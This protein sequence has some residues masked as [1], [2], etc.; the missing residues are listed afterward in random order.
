MPY[1]FLEVYDYENSKSNCEQICSYFDEVYNISDQSS[2][3]SGLS[4]FNKKRQK[5]CDTKSFNFGEDW[6]CNEIVYSFISDSISSYV[7]KYSFLET[8]N[9]GAHWRLCPSYNIQRYEGEKEG[10]FTLHNENS[11]TYPYRMLVWMVYLN[12]AKCG[13]EFPYQDKTVTPKTGRTVIWPAGWTHPHDGVTPNQGTKYIATG[14][15][16]FLPKGDAP[17]FDGHHPDEENIKEIVV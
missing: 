9:K 3:S 6:A 5:I 10:F 7:K 12:D 1:D 8:L 4:Y 13:T 17:K 2:K 11:G 14:W 15:F 16:Y